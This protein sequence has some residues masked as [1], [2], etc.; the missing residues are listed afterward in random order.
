MK[1]LPIGFF[2]SGVGGISV[3]AEAYR[4]L[5]RE[6]FIYFCDSRN[7]PYGEKSPSEVRDLSLRAADYLGHHGIKALVVA[8]NTATSVAINT[9][10]EQLSIPVIGMEPAL[11][12]AAEMTGLGS[13][14][15]MATPLTLREEK[16]R[17]LLERYRG[18]REIIPLPCPGLV[19]MIEQGITRGVEVNTYLRQL[20]SGLPGQQPVAIVLGC[21]HY[22]FI[23]EELQQVL[24][25][26]VRF[27][28]GNRG[29]VNH[30]KRQL[31]DQDL[32]NTGRITGSNRVKIDTT[33]DPALVLPLCRL[34]LDSYSDIIGKAGHSFNQARQASRGR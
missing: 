29:T 28:D 5:P 12:P 16:F 21:T 18:V 26:G 7:A 15:V 2:D 1:T 4:L 22:L 25:T 11:K 32:L 33:G 20:L 13:I 14:V 19:A 23:R 27:F 34:L 17:L 10:R 30:L 3:L 31:A 6:K 9:M 24:G 8:C